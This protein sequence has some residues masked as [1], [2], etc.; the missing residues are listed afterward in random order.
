MHNSRQKFFSA[1]FFETAGGKQPV[2]EFIKELTK[3]EQK[4]IGADINVVQKNF[5]IGLPLVKKI[6]PKLWEIRST[7]KDGI[8]RIFFTIFAEKII[9]LHIFVKKTQKTPPKEIDIAIE[10]LKEFK[11]MQK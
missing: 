5:P 10:R 9:L 3:E 4:E 7:I 2:K 11:R 8:C 1:V 6:K